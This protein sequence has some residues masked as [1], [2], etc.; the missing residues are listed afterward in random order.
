M[1]RQKKIKPIKFFNPIPGIVESYPIVEAKKFKRTWLEDNGR[2]LNQFKQE[3]KKCP[4]T[5]LRE[6]ITSVSFISRCPGIRQFM[7]R[8]YIIPNPVDFYVETNGDRKTIGVAPMHP[9]NSGHIFKVK[10]HP[11]EQLHA[12]SAVPLNSCKTVLKVSTG[13]NVIPHK[14]YVFIV[15]S[16]HYN[17]EP[18]FTSAVGVLDPAYDTQINIFLFW[19]ALEGRELVKAG[20]P[21]AQYIP[22]PRDL[23]QPEIECEFLRKE[24]YDEFF[25]AHNLIYNYLTDEG[26]DPNFLRDTALKIFKKFS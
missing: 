2:D 20:T 12:Y 4:I 26:R 22:V 16:P 25:A 7:N 19:H 10:F 5:E 13:W 14:D 18:R 8:G 11:E 15:T 17:N 24:Q 9:P 1:P 3:L 6:K 23:I 21:L